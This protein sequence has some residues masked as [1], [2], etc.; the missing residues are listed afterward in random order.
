MMVPPVRKRCCHQ[1]DAARNGK[2]TARPRK[3][4][5]GQSLVG[6]DPRT[7][8]AG[9]PGMPPRMRLMPP[10]ITRDDVAHLAG[11][12]RIA[13]SEEELDRLGPELSKIVE[14]VATVSQA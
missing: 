11:L 8:V 5:D 2:S 6:D 7:H 10:E 3:F 1:L 13:L 12:A 9:A 4:S 14:S